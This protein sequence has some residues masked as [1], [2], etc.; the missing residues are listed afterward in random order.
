MT[1]P[2]PRCEHLDHDPLFDPPSSGY[3]EGHAWFFTL[4]GDTSIW[5]CRTCFDRERAA[6]HAYVA[7]AVLDPASRTY[8]RIGLLEKWLDILC[9]FAALPAPTEEVAR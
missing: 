8:Q 9:E 6:R 3:G 1:T 5:L 7:A 4:C 2:M